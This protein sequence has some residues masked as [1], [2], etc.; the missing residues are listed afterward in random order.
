MAQLYQPIKGCLGDRDV[1]TPNVPVLDQQHVGPARFDP[2]FAD[3]P[4]PSRLHRCRRAAA[5]AG[6]RQRPRRHACLAPSTGRPGSGSSRHCGR[7]RDQRASTPVMAPAGNSEA[8]SPVALLPLSPRQCTSRLTS[9]AVRSSKPMAV[10]PA[11][12]RAGPAALA[13]PCSSA[14]SVPEQQSETCLIAVLG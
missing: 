1:T 12:V 11:L 4:T 13:V 10:M 7:W 6:S 8:R 3:S 5:C 2:T 9:K 14:S